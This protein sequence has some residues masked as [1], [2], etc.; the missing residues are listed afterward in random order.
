MKI[1]Y[2]LAELRAPFFTAAIM[3]ILLGT[4]IAWRETGKFQIIYFVAV[5]IA[6]VLLQAGANVS[7][8]YFDHKSGCDN[9]NREFLRPFTGGSRMI[10]DGHLTP[11][12]VMTE[13]IICY[14]I[15]SLIGIWL[16]HE[17]GVVILWLGLIGIA[18]GI[19]YTAPP[20]KLVS[21]GFGELLIGLNFGVLMT[22]GSYYCQTGSFAW[23]PVFASIPVALLITA[24]LY[25]NEFP[26][27]VADKAVGKRHLVARLGRKGAVVG[28]YLLLALTYV[29]VGVGVVLKMLPVWGI[30]VFLTIPLAIK[31][32]KVIRANYDNPVGLAPANSATIQLHLFIG[33]IL[34]ATYIISGHR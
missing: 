13:A 16:I 29:F 32:I 5:L 12:A 18:S 15:A 30:A 17:C 27:Y 28:Y 4:A 2:Y 1:K 14:L 26:D 19:L 25:I 10:Q 23:L 31:A 6:G 34:S 7:N 11:R 22:L 21:R 20:F 24:V 9:I 33:L 8:D 3:P